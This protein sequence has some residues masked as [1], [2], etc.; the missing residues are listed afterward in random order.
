[1]NNLLIFVR[2]ASPAL[3][4]S[5]YCREHFVYAPNQFETTL[6][7][8]IVSHWLGALS[9]CQWGNCEGYGLNQHVPL[10]PHYFRTLTMSKNRRTYC[11]R[12]KH[13]N[14]SMEFI[15]A[16]I[17]SVRRKCLCGCYRCFRVNRMCEPVCCGSLFIP[18][19][20][21]NFVHFVR[22]FMD[23]KLQSKFISRNNMRLYLSSVCKLLLS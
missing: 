21:C 13:V 8:N 10:S 3:G 4:Q 18:D 7:C 19:K 14:Y 20:R 17:V 15:S 9:E 11:K 22:I 5:Y 23:Q 16:I 6:Q 12:Y 1:M 2:A